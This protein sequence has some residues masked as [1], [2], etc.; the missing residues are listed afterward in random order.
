MLRLVYGHE[1]NFCADIDGNSKKIWMVKTK[2][3][4]RRVRQDSRLKT[5]LYC[6]M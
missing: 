4:F 2:D 1:H 6:Y 3:N 5:L